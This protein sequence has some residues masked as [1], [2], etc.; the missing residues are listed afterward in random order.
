M[1]DPSGFADLRNYIK[2][3]ISKARYRI[4]S[5]YYPAE[6]NEISIQSDNTVRVVLDI[7]P[8]QTGVTVTRVELLNTDDQL[9]AHQ[10]CRIT[11]GEGQTSILFWFDFTI[12]EEEK[13]V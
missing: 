8:A 12:T 4:G 3:R 13:E 1:I 7:S 6:I 2:R 10:D 5:T 11:I 9:W